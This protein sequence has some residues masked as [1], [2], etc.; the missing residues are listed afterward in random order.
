[1]K[2]RYFIAGRRP[3]YL[4]EYHDGSLDCYALDWM[5]A[6]MVRDL[7]YLS[8]I[9]NGDSE[10]IEVNESTFSNAVLSIPSRVN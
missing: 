5:T 8:Q 6:T 3:V 9:A 10:I 1:M 7:S 4:I 2:F